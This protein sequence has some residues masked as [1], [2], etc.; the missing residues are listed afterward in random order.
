MSYQPLRV[1]LPQSL[2]Q[3]PPVL[4]LTLRSDYYARS[5]SE[6]RNT[7]APCII[8]DIDNPTCAEQRWLLPPTMPSEMLKVWSLLH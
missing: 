8:L 7:A 2:N 3:Q 4:I 1:N 6:S 5:R